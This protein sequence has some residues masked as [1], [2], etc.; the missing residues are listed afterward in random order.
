MHGAVRGSIPHHERDSLPRTGLL[1]ANGMTRC[2]QG[3]L[4]QTQSTKI[5]FALR[6][7]RAV[8]PWSEK[9][10]AHIDWSLQSV[11]SGSK[12]LQRTSANRALKSRSTAL[13]ACTIASADGIGAIFALIDT[14]T[15]GPMCSVTSLN[16]LSISSRE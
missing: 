11:T 15:S 6:Y 9:L 10:P 7:R 8:P 5:P 3:T 14:M 16:T 13:M 1:A 12:K 2:E 4:L